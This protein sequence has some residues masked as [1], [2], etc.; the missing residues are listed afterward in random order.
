LISKEEFS[1]SF[2]YLDRANSSLLTNNI[3]P[4]VYPTTRSTSTT[5]S[6]DLS[7]AFRVDAHL[8]AIIRI[9]DK[10]SKFEKEKY[11]MLFFFLL[12]LKNSLEMH[13]LDVFYV[14]LDSYYSTEVVN[15]LRQKEQKQSFI[16]KPCSLFVTE[17]FFIIFDRGTQV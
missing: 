6:P 7:R 9:E 2:L 8:L 3:L 17:R 14:S 16:N 4:D 13:M 1:F 5:F 12:Y 15:K 10:R 11:E